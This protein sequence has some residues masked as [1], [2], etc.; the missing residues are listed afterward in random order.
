MS[1][2]EFDLNFEEQIILFIFIK[3]FHSFTQND[4]NQ[5]KLKKQ[6]LEKKWY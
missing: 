6:S 5:I 3:T 1:F 2:A 4:K